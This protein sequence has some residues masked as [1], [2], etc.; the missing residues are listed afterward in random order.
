M[1]HYVVELAQTLLN[2]GFDQLSEREQRVIRRIA[3]RVHIS[4]NVNHEFDTQLTLGQR[5]ADR[6][7]AFGGSWTFIILF[8]L[9]LVLWVVLNSVVLARAGEAFDPYPY[10]FLNL[11]L[12]MLAAIQA[13][14]IMMSQNRQVVKDRLDAAHDFEVNLKAE[15]EIMQL[16]EKLDQIRDQQIKELLTLQQEH[17]RLLALLLECCPRPEAT[18][19]QGA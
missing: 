15:L 5:L 16:H 12:S 7:A 2:T 3:K 4:R 18:P 11:V 8:T 6:V 14:V 1:N 9:I 13:P 19:P 10:V 17:S